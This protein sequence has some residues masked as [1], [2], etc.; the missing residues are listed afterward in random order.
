MQTP[1]LDSGTRPPST[2]SHRSSPAVEG[3]EPGNTDSIDFKPLIQF[4]QQRLH[5]QFASFTI[6]SVVFLEPRPLMPELRTLQRDGSRTSFIDEWLYDIMS[7][8]SVRMPL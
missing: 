4:L 8:H 2:G 3:L 6:K 7:E 5:P 1:C